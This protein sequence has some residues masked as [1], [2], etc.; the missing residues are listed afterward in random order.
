[1]EDEEDMYQRCKDGK[2][3]GAYK[4]WKGVQLT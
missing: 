4:V 1:M 3:P 2:Y